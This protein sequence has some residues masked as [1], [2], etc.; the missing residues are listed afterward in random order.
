MFGVL[1]IAFGVN[2][3]SPLVAVEIEGRTVLEG[4]VL[5]YGIIHLK[6]MIHILRIHLVAV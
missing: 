4:Q 2:F 5:V 3:K 6:G 1:E